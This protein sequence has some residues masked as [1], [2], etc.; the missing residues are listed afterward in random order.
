MKRE[1]SGRNEF[2][3]R[4]KKLNGK[5]KSSSLPRDAKGRYEVRKK[6]DFLLT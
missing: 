6:E 4:K 1:G 3:K 2:K 5:R